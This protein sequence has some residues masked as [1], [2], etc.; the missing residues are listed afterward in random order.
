MS[1]CIKANI[2]QLNEQNYCCFVVTFDTQTVFEVLG[3]ISGLMVGRIETLRFEGPDT[4]IVVSK[5]K[6]LVSII[7]S[8]RQIDMKLTDRFL[9]LLA[10]VCYDK[11]FNTYP[12]PH[13]D[14]E[15]DD[16]EI[17]FQWSE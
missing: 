1:F 17:T 13:F 11:A 7:T 9:E 5:K 10:C 4:V 12:F 15:S 6:E 2:E 14:Y 8:G 16:Y 3:R